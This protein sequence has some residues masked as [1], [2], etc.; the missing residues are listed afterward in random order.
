MSLSFLNIYEVELDGE[1]R[2]LVCFLEPVLAGARG[3]EEASD[4]RVLRQQ[5]PPARS[6]CRLLSRAP[7]SIWLQDGG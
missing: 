2:H 7:R 4:Q 3:I 6:R 1:N 5:R